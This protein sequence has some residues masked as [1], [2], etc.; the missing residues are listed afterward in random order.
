[1]SSY[2][3]ASETARRVA[4]GEVSPVEV[5]EVALAR[6]AEVNPRLN[7]IVTLNPRAL[8]DARDLERRLARRGRGAAGRRSGRDQG[9]DPWVAGLRTTFGSPLYADHVP[10]EDGAC[11]AAA[12]CGGRDH[13]RQTNTPEFAA[14]GNTWNDVFGRTRNPRDPSRS[15]GGS[16]GGR[17][18]SPPR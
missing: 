16:T 2:R 11:G 6:V 18:A 7:A 8:D 14:G 15:A 17:W 12:P 5:I 10:E 3:S 1:M 4:A 13:P 9:R